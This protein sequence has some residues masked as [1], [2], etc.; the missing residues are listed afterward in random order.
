[1]E[2]AAL[3][4]PGLTPQTVST[5]LNLSEQTDRSYTQTLIEYLKTKRLL[6]ML[7]NCEHLLNACAAL[8]DALRRACPHLK[9][10]ATSREGLGIAG[11]QTY[12]VPSLTVPDLTQ[13]LT[14]DRL[15]QYE[16]VRLFIE[17]AASSRTDFTV[18]DQEAPA[19]ASIA[20]RL[21]G[22]PLA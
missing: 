3:A 6:L 20:H 14:L 5:F 8:A 17:R 4:D 9:I 12:R 11:E 1:V 15:R 13:T 21:D 22:I 18:S 2:L 10:L 16:A 19:L 7:D